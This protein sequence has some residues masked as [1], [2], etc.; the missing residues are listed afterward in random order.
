MSITDSQRIYL[1]SQMFRLSKC[2]PGDEG[3]PCDCPMRAVSQMGFV[4]KYDWIHELSDQRLVE[5][6]A[7]HHK[8]LTKKTGRSRTRPRLTPALFSDDP[9]SQ[10]EGVYAGV[11]LS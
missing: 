8:C 2:T 1:L 5:L 4:E 11:G 6:L 7:R 10:T 9:K 3:N